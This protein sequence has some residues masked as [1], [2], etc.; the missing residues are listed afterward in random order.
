[1]IKINNIDYKEI[2]DAWKTSFKPTQIQ[3]ELAQ[4]RLNVCLGCNFRKEVLK[5]IEWS[6]YCDDC[7][8]PINKKVFSK[9]FNPCTQRKWKDVD[10]E[11]ITPIDDKNKK[12]LL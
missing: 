9:L 2:F 1:M 3:E 8:C 11:Y 4:K 12:T 5:G 7:G 6:A 10:S